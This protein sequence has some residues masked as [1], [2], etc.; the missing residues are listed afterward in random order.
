MS[1]SVVDVRDVALAHVRGLVVPSAAGKR[2]LLSAGTVW[3]GEVA[4]VLAKEFGPKGYKLP[5]MKVGKAVMQVV[6]LWDKTVKAVLPGVGKL[7]RYS[8]LETKK[9]LGIDFISIEKTF[10]DTGASLI[11]LGGINEPKGGSVKA[12]M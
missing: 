12:K 11:A 2:F 3:L 5:S 10:V 1:L 9:V 4:S 7:V 6:A 8:N